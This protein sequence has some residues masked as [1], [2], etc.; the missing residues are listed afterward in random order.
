MVRKQSCRRKN[1]KEKQ[2][3]WSCSR[4]PKTARRHVQK[5]T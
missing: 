5:Y 4:P 2:R 1:S 3:T